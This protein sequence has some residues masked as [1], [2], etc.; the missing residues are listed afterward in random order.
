M[1]SAYH[2]QAAAGGNPLDAVSVRPAGNNKNFPC[3]S[4]KYVSQKDA[5][6][7]NGAM[8]QIS[9][10]NRTAQNLLNCHIHLSQAVISRESLLIGHIQRIRNWQGNGYT[11][12]EPQI[13]TSLLHKHILPDSDKCPEEI[14]F[15]LP[16]WRIQKLSE[17]RNWQNLSAKYGQTNF[18]GHYKWMQYS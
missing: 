10:N 3:C 5:V 12:K 14:L 17:N 8:L 16:D 6:G 4:N 11:Q 7:D 9:N 1:Y 2:F 15:F 18:P 13:I